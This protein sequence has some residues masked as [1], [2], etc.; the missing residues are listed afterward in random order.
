MLGHDGFGQPGLGD[1]NA[2][3]DAANEMGDLLP[4]VSLGTGRTARAIFAGHWNTCV[5]LDNDQIK[6]WGYNVGGQ[7]GQGDTNNRGDGAGEMGA[8][9]QAIN[10]GTGRTATSSDSATSR[11]AATPPAKW[12]TCYS[13]STSAPVER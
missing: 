11:A 3:G 1:T 8:A 6:R 5:I 12:A 7:L 9:L 10:V 13:P 2:R 4:A